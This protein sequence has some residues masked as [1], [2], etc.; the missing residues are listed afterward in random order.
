MKTGGAELKWSFV[1]RFLRR[2][3]IKSHSER[4]SIHRVSKKEGKRSGFDPV[5]LPGVCPRSDLYN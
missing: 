5:P 2:A 4:Q 1:N 3:K